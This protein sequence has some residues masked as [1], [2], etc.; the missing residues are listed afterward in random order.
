M[1]ASR[2]WQHNRLTSEPN[3]VQPRPYLPCSGGWK[4]HS[5]RFDRQEASASRSTKGSHGL[6]QKY[7]SRTWIHADRWRCWL[8]GP[9]V[10]PMVPKGHSLTRPNITDYL[11]QICIFLCSRAGN[12]SRKE[13][14][15]FSSSHARAVVCLASREP[16]KMQV[17][18]SAHKFFKT[19][20]PM[21]ACAS[22]CPIFLELFSASFLPSRAVGR[23]DSVARCLPGSQTAA[24]MRCH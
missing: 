7:N 3:S 10:I 22:R 4:H 18:I 19:H 13:R 14:V 9:A 1:T 24:R 20:P 5:F 17:E 16:R 6:G 21:R 23:A 15:F 2:L 11:G 8:R 12:G